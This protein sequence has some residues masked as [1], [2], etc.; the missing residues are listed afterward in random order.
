[1]SYTISIKVNGTDISN[2]LLSEF[3]TWD[4]VTYIL[5]VFPTRNEHC[6]GHTFSI[7]FDDGISVPVTE[8]WLINLLFNLPLVAINSIPNMSVIVGNVDVSVYDKMLYFEDPE[9][10]P[11]TT[12]WR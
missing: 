7:T 8:T 2:P 6:G 1:L 12:L 11:F 10:M 3:I 5:D 4:P 9:S